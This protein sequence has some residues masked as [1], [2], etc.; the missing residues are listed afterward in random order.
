M[1]HE[2]SIFSQLSDLDLT[3]LVFP[4]IC[5]SCNEPLLKLETQICL[6]CQD[7][8]PFS[9]SWVSGQDSPVGK[10]FLDR[11]DI[12]EAHSLFQYQKGGMV[13]RMLRKLKYDGSKEVGVGLGELFG[14]I[15]SEN[16]LGFAAD[17]FVAVPLHPAK[18]LRRGYNQSDMIVKGLREHID[19][20]DLSHLIE[21]T[22]FTESQ[23]SK[24]RYQR[25]E[26]MDHV[27]HCPSPHKVSGLSLIVVDDVITTGSTM[28]ACINVLSHAGA[29][30]FSVL[31]LAEA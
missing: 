14:K 29:S 4:R 6:I 28:K 10:L 30:S 8:L 25:F 27:F 31:T 3:E 22:L 11:T 24:S 9:R 23:T 2:N 5:I 18:I 21:R 13:Q 16:S 19:L 7:Q 17:G 20:P 12:N 26:N 1:K 15:L